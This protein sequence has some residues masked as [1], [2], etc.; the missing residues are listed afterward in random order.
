[1]KIN[2][3]TTNE[4][5]NTNRNGCLSS[6]NHAIYLMF[7]ITL[8]LNFPLPCGNIGRPLSRKKKNTVMC[9]CLWSSLFFSR[10]LFVFL[11]DVFWR[12]VILFMCALCCFVFQQVS[13]YV[14]IFCLFAWL[15]SV[16]LSSGVSSAVFVFCCCVFVC[17]CMTS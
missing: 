1:M 15:H 5:E 2:H 8:C 14:R 6:T 12:G 11:C 7:V 17:L 9:L 3:N 16:G 10:G 13:V 4:L